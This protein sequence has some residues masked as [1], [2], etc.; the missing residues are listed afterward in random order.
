M[1]WLVGQSD[2][3][4][5]VAVRN[6]F[7]PRGINSMV[8]RDAAGALDVLE[9]RRVQAAIVDMDF[10]RMSGLSV[11]KI[12]RGYYPALPCILV[13][14]TSQRRL[15]TRALELNV[16]SVIAKPVDMTILQEQLNKLFLKRYS[17]NI[18]GEF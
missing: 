10:E 14:E 13:S 5:P 18:F 2:W 4:W 12:I 15:L 3:A 16:F 6:I 9:R 7:E 1:Y 17:S 8:V 11:I